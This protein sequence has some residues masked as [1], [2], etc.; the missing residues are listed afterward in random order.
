MGR[1][2]CVP[3]CVTWLFAVT[4]QELWLSISNWLATPVIELLCNSDKLYMKAW[5]SEGV[6]RGSWP[7]SGS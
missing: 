2:S 3:M 4:Q 5:A 7:L 6:G 1:C